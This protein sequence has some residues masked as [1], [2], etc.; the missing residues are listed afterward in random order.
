MEAVFLYLNL[1]EFFMA[2]NPQLED[3]IAKRNELD[4]QIRELH[5]K[6]D[7]IVHVCTGVDRRRDILFV[8]FSDFKINDVRFDYEFDINEDS[9][10]VPEFFADCG[11]YYSY[12]TN[13]NDGTTIDAAINKI[14]HYYETYKQLRELL[15]RMKNNGIRYVADASDSNVENY[16]FEDNN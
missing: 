1:K 15:L 6:Q 14:D 8:D 10:N 2:S 11:T 4:E 3:L 12:A 13:D 5:R 9:D 16:D 7:G